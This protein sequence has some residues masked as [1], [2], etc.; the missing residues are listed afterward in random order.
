[1]LNQIPL[2]TFELNEMIDKNKSI[3]KE[4]RIEIKEELKESLQFIYNKDYKNAEI[5]LF[6]IGMDPTLPTKIALKIDK[7]LKIIKPLTK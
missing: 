6:T 5:C 7:I 4:D 3:C 2:L 1:M